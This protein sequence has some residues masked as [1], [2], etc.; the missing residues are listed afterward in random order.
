MNHSLRSCLLLASIAGTAGAMPGQSSAKLKDPARVPCIEV[1]GDTQSIYTASKPFVATWVAWTVQKRDDGTDLAPVLYL[2][3]MARDSSGKVHVE[4]QD[5]PQKGISF[6]TFWVD[7]P[8]SG[9]S[10]SWSELDKV[11]TVFHSP[12]IDSREMQELLRKLPWAKEI[13][14]VPLCVTHGPDSAFDRDEFSIQDLGTSQIL[15]IDAQGILATRN[16]DP[17][18]EERWYSSDLQIALTTRV[19]DSRFGQSVREVKSLERI[20]PDQSLFRIPAGYIL[21]DAASPHGENR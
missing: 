17:I 19:N 16:N 12:R 9:T 20:E 1:F 11:V 21:V 8:V 18:T 14:A 10:Y 5:R 6:K 4:G 15:G 2:I 7:D 3:K 13:W